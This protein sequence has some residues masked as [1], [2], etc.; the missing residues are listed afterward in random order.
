[1]VIDFVG[2]WLLRQEPTSK[3][4]VEGTFGLLR[5]AGNFTCDTGDIWL[6]AARGTS[7]AGQRSG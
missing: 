5:K 2:K 1:M 7:V 6:P 3:T 4:L